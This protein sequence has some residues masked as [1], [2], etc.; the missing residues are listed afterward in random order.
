MQKFT[1][2]Q[3][4]IIVYRDRVYFGK[5][6]VAKIKY[7]DPQVDSFLDYK[8]TT[9]AFL[10]DVS[11]LLNQ[12]A[13]LSHL[14]FIKGNQ[15]FPILEPWRLKTIQGRLKILAV[16]LPFRLRIRGEFP[17]TL[18]KLIKD[19]QEETTSII[20]QL[21]FDTAQMLAWRNG[22]AHRFRYV[23]D[24][25]MEVK[26]KGIKLEAKTVDSLEQKLR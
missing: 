2:F 7:P 12:D 3:D 5:D 19:I 21:F 13:I 11:D 1:R 15:E 14:V 10:L 25:I 20:K 26:A 23:Y 24:K 4:G 6:S 9:Y 18:R 8:L 16:D 17:E 22:D